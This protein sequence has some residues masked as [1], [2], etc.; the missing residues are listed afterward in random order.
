MINSIRSRWPEKAGFTISRP[1]G[2]NEYTFLHF[3]NSVDI[4]VDGK[5]IK[6]KPN[7]CIFYAPHTEQWFK[8]E[9]PLVH[10][11][12]HTDLTLEKMLKK[13]N[14]SENKIYYPR[15][16]DFVFSSIFLLE[17][18]F[19]GKQA[20]S[21]DLMYSG[22]VEFLI[23]FSRQTNESNREVLDKNNVSEMLKI[24]QQIF[25]NLGRRWT[26]KDMANLAHI[27]ESRFYDKY[28]A[29]FSV[30][31]LK[32]LICARITSAENMLSLGDKSVKEIA[33]E[34]GYTNEFHFIRQFHKIKGVSPGA[35]KN[36]QRRD[37]G[38]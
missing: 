7:A 9:E 18:E 11:W 4:M 27:S 21:E 34:L 15:Q 29:A 28:K 25:A 23:N 2:H 17:N 10:N 16:V 32:D 33:A 1:A 26:V 14:I 13:Y 19:F 24:R 5:I 20:Y 12:F 36:A 6:T 31:P 3:L 22:L 35:F 8:S 38:V 30:S 37:N